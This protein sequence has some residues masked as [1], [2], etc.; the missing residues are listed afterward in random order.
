VVTQEGNQPLSLMSGL[1]FGAC[2]DVADPIVSAFR[3][4]ERKKKDN[5]R[6][7]SNKQ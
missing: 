5:A 7:L 1:I 6:G 2:S 4:K 3:K